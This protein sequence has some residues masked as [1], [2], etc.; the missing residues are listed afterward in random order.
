MCQFRHSRQHQAKFECLAYKAGFCK[1]GPNCKALHVRRELCL[2]YLAGFC[3]DGPSCTNGHPLFNEE[4][5]IT[6]E[7][8]D[9]LQRAS[10]KPISTNTLN[11]GAPTANAGPGSGST[12]YGQNTSRNTHFSQPSAGYGQPNQAPNTNHL[13]SPMEFKSRHG[14]GFAA[15]GPFAQQQ[16]GQNQGGNQQFS[17]KRSYAEITCFKCQETGHYANVCPKSKRPRND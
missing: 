4:H 8:P 12:G 16:Q 6:G 11:P 7:W 15:S 13:R 1:Q 10:N 5:V 9:G 3:S 14:S 17:G 2:K